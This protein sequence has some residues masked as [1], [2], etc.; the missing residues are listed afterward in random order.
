M[1][2]TISAK[3][4]PCAYTAGSFARESTVNQW[5]RYQAR[6]RRKARL[7]A[8]GAWT[9]LILAAIGLVFVSWVVVIAV[10][11]GLPA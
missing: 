8:I 7:Q 3:S 6:E 2:T 1:R 4:L 9:V 11:A 10:Y 5:D